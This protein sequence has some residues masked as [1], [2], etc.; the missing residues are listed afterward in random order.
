MKKLLSI[1]LSVLFIVVSC[2]TLAGCDE[3]S[4]FFNNKRGASKDASPAPPITTPPVQEAQFEF[5]NYLE[6]V[7]LFSSLTQTSGYILDETFQL[8]VKISCLDEFGHSSNILKV[9]SIPQYG[10]YGDIT[11]VLIYYSDPSE[12]VNEYFYS[13]SDYDKTEY[14]SSLLHP[15]SIILSNEEISSFFSKNNSDGSISLRWSAVALSNLPFGNTPF[16]YY[17]YNSLTARQIT[18]TF[19]YN[20]VT[21]ITE[22]DNITIET[23]IKSCRND[24]TDTYYPESIL[25]L[26]EFY[27]LI[28]NAIDNGFEAQIGIETSSGFENYLVTYDPNSTTEYN[29]ILS[30]SYSNS[31]IE[32]N[33]K[34]FDDIFTFI[35]AP[36]FLAENLFYDNLDSVCLYIDGLD[37]LSIDGNLSQP[38]DIMI[39]SKTLPDSWKTLTFNSFSFIKNYDSTNCLLSIGFTSSNFSGHINFIN[40]GS[41][42]IE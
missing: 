24:K 39:S 23:T 18:A 5:P 20:E 42:V 14:I 2:F 1:F 26:T 21:F 32:K 30:D 13:Y 11:D 25:V 38:I 34:E 22:C 27:S 3:L 17:K 16:D 33:S 35:F 28:N 10:Y 37:I 12:N 9:I 29:L 36:T 40:I 6:R 8:N 7:R 19:D 31:F 41:T 15:F 4:D